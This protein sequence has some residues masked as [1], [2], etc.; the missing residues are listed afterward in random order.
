M[1]EAT[2]PHCFEVTWKK[3]TGN[4]SGYKIYCFPADSQKAEIVK[5]IVYRNQLS[6]IISGLKPETV[7][8][9]AITSVSSGTESKPVFAKDDV[10]L[11]KSIIKSIIKLISWRKK[12]VGN[13]Y[14]V[15]SW[16]PSF[17]FGSECYDSQERLNNRE[18][19][20]TNVG[21]EDGYFAI[22]HINCQKGKSDLSFH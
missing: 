4:V 22:Q 2:N 20:W 16:N 18:K 13:A 9:V 14:F 10:T 6:E 8:R 7:Y 5:D 21:E 11:R 12:P 3:A 15:F 1:V 17:S 19:H